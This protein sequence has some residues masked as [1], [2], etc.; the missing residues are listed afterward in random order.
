M[1]VSNCPKTG[2]K[3]LLLRVGRQLDPK[4]ANATRGLCGPN[5]AAFENLTSFSTG[6][7]FL[8]HPENGIIRIADN[9]AI[10]GKAG[11]VLRNT[12]FVVVIVA[13][14]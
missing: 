5:T 2:C 8:L 6:L 11:E 7:A 12:S 9:S 13:E 3:P 10:K 14:F 4:R 1:P